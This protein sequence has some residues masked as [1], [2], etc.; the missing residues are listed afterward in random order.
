[1]NNQ[2]NPLIDIIAGARPNFM[3]V[4]SIIKAIENSKT[5]LLRYR[6][7]HT[8][9]HYDDSMSNLFFTQL[10][11]PKPQINFAVGSGTQAEQTG[12]IMVQYEKLLREQSSQLCL[13][14]G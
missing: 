5:S 2:S 9:Q 11:I 12:A 7:I 14:V 13:V 8:G 1:M 4:R 3:K 10:N 6:L